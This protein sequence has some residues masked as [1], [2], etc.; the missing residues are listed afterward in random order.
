MDELKYLDSSKITEDKVINQIVKHFPITIQVYVKTTKKQFL[1]IWKKLGKI[2]NPKQN[3]EYSG[4]KKCNFN[5]I[6]KHNQMRYSQLNNSFRPNMND[7]KREY[8][9]N[10]LLSNKTTWKKKF[11]FW[12]KN[13]KKMNQGTV[14]MY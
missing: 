9:S 6:P 8:T 11:Q 4:E 13:K 5:G 3:K 12:T 1:S 10:K 2:Q 14:D 7:P